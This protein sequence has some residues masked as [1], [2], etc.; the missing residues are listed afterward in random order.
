MEL[1]S[2]ALSEISQA[3]SLWGLTGEALQKQDHGTVLGFL[4]RFHYLVIGQRK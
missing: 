1:E 3:V 4:W 2:I